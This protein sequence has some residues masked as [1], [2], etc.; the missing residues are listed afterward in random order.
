MDG[1]KTAESEGPPLLVAKKLSK[2][3]TGLA[4]DLKTFLDR[5]KDMSY[6]LEEVITVPIADFENDVKYHAGCLEELKGPFKDRTVNRYVSDLSKDL[7]EHMDR[8]KN[9]L[10]TVI[11]V[12]LPAI[13][14]SQERVA[15]SLQNLSAVSPIAKVLTT[16]FTVGTSAGLLCTGLW[17]ILE[18]LAYAKTDGQKLLLDILGGSIRKIGDFAKFSANWV[19]MVKAIPGTLR[20][21]VER[22]MSAM[23]KKTEGTNERAQRDEESQDVIMQTN[24][25][26]D[27][28]PMG[29]EYTQG[30]L[31][32]VNTVALVA[33]KHPSSSGRNSKTLN[34]KPAPADLPVPTTEGTTPRAPEKPTSGDAVK[35]VPSHTQKVTAMLRSIRYSRIPRIHEGSVK[36]LQFSPDGQHLAI[37][38]WDGAVFIWRLGLGDQ[39]GREILH[40]LLHQSRMGGP[41]KQVEWSPRGVLL[42]TKQPK[43]MQLWNAMTGRHIK[44]F[45]AQ[46]GHRVQSI[47]WLSPSV[48]PSKFLSVEWKMVTEP[49]QVEKKARFEEKVVGSTLIIRAARFQTTKSTYWLDRLQVWDAAMTP[50]NERVVVV[51]TL[52]QTA[53]G[54]K[55]RKSRAQKQILLYNLKNRQIESP[56]P[57]MQEARN[58]TLQILTLYVLETEKGIHALVSYGD[59][60]PS[61]MW[62]IKSNNGGEPSWSL[63]SARRYYPESSSE[64]TTISSCFAGVN[65]QFV[66]CVSESGSVD[67]RDRSDGTSL[68]SLKGPGQVG[69][70]KREADHLLNARM[71][72]TAITSSNHDPSEGIM[73]ASAA[74]EGD[75]HIWSTI[76]SPPPATCGFP[77]MEASDSNFAE[78]VPVGPLV[79]SS[80]SP[81]TVL[82]SVIASSSPS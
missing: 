62:R 66:V 7:I 75:V 48:W 76:A 23:W 56:V 70:S 26:T 36:Q 2:E 31:P 79:D 17:L 72:L 49:A 67:I 80:A 44:E 6:F 11:D 55:P 21:L 39:G 35:P 64:S 18:R 37:C 51:A 15:T 30:Q 32:V 59:G 45:R 3:M 42:L 71:Q 68:H 82:P 33:T 38:S 5:L 28:S 60:T 13:R 8:M 29:R 41:A 78:E 12:S 57:L 4:K 47:T 81:E 52:V 61:E 1:S 58:V 50:D 74:E 22:L 14:A 24:S 16:G 10:E 9:S 77:P 27:K 46:E 69:F 19:V 54:C 65:D 25:P 53:R 20:A 63:E 73:L 34:G 43:S 40:V